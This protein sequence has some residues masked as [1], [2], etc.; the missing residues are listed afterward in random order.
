MRRLLLFAFLSV[1]FVSVQAQPMLKYRTRKVLGK[2]AVVLFAAQKELKASKNYT[3]DFA[4][5]VAHQRFAKRLFIRRNFRIAAEHSRFARTL[6]FKVLRDNKAIIQKDWEVSADE[7]E[8]METLSDKDLRDELLKMNS[9]VELKDE[10]L[11]NDTLKD[12]DVDDLSD[13]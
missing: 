9:N 3:G 6:A 2:T 1:F 5:A 8:V 13:Q 11:M 12:V 7:Q 4:M 10:D